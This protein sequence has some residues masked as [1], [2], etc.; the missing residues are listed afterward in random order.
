MLLT[1]DNQID[2]LAKAGKLTEE[3]RAH[4]VE[5]ADHEGWQVAKP[6]RPALRISG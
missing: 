3:G 5:R 1:S 2:A 4:C 6:V